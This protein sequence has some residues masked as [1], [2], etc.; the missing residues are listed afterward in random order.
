MSESK[1]LLTIIINADIQDLLVDWLLERGDLDFFDSYEMKS[2]KKD[3]SGYSVIERVTGWKR[4]VAMTT[5]LHVSVLETL[6]EDLK[7]HFAGS[8][9]RYTIAPVVEEGII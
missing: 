6:L 5:I 2:Y 8:Q 9:I 4:K 7:L 1:Q 3:H